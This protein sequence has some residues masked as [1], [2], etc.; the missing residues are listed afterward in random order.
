MAAIN[1][2]VV[3]A[4]VGG[5]VAYVTF[6]NTITLSV[7]GEAET[8]HT[9][10][11]TVD[12]VLASE[13]IELGDRDEVVPSLDSEVSDGSEVAVRYGRQ[14]S[15]T[16][17][18]DE[19]EIWTTALSVD[20]FLSELGLRTD[21]ADMTVSRSRSIGR[22]GIDFEVRTAK[23]L[24]LLADGDKTP[25]V[26]TA[27]TVREAL[28]EADV[29]IGSLDIVEP[30]LE[31]PLTEIEDIT[32][33]RVTVETETVE[34]DIEHDTKEEESS[35]LDKGESEVITEGKDGV[36][37]KVLEKTYIDGELEDTETLEENVI[38]EPITEVIRI[39]TAE[40]DDGGDDGGGDG[41]SDGGVWDRLAQCESGGNWSINTGNGYYGG[42]QFNL[43]TWQAYGGSGYPHENSKEEQIRIATKLRDDRGGYGAWPGCASK[44]GLPT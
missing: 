12:G 35:K 33:K 41:G 15:V 20:E 11:S 39:G 7:D 6:D 23:E 18:G 4:L 19:Q 43:Q 29:E 16:V 22:S 38:E 9:F 44:L 14:V 32:V 17:D 5:G 40:P 34:K 24:T 42:L 8:V 28:S 13:G 1:G 31:E 21:G 36:L 37:E 26:T 2:A 25:L 27:L 10:A 30:D 3:A